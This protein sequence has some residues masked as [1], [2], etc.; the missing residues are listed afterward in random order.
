MKVRSDEKNHI[1]QVIEDRGRSDPWK[2]INMALAPRKRS[3]LIICDENGNQEHNVAEV[4]NQA[5]VNKIDKIK[6][7]IKLE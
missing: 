6:E 3:R 1:K 5:F 4:L 7:S 2:A